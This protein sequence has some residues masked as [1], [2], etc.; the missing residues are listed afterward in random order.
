MREPLSLYVDELS[1]D[2]IKATVS[3]AHSI[4]R[5]IDT[6]K[7]VSPQAATALENPIGG[8]SIVPAGRYLCMVIWSVDSPTVAEGMIILNLRDQ[9]ELIDKMAEKLPHEALRRK[10]RRIGQ[11]IL[12]LPEIRPKFKLVEGKAPDIFRI[13]IHNIQMIFPVPGSIRS[14][15][16]GGYG[17][18]SRIPVTLV[19]IILSL[20]LFTAGCYFFFFT[21]A[22]FATFL[23]AFFAV[24]LMAFF[25][26]A[27]AF[28]A[29]LA[30]AFLT[31]G[32][33]A[34]FLVTAFFA[35][36]FLATDFFGAAFLGAFFLCVIFLMAFLTAVIFSAVTST[37]LSFP[38]TISSPRTAKAS[39]ASAKNP[40]PSWP[41]CAGF[42][43]L[44]ILLF[45]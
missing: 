45:S 40:F 38:S 27:T 15:R 10:F 4:L 11:E 39:P 5:N 13:G 22:F 14:W 44:L 16:R 43:A 9:P 28:F 20:L 42:F 32:F 24:F 33:F 31:T 35:T 19:V 25:G 36:T 30:A 23:I 26:A 6:I 2:Q 1:P 41:G 18:G 8:V 37:I 3:D 21:G 7:L 17:G 29:T 12:D 34:D